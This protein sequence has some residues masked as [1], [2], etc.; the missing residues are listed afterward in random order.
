MLVLAATHQTN[1]DLPGD[2]DYCVE[3]ELVYL[4][5]PCD[6][7]RRDPDGG[8]G[9]GRAFS[10]MSSRRATTTARVIEVDMTEDDVREALRAS[11]VA[12]GWLNPS[13]C[14]PELANE[15]VTELYEDVRAMAA[16]FPVGGVVRRRLDHCYLAPA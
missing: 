9:C 2:F 1:G 15:M 6:R 7:D 5:D 11:L 14:T 10:G 13:F 12:G 3:G 8:C 16:H 4:Q